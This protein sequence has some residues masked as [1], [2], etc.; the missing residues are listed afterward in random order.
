M[1]LDRIFD[2]FS[3]RKEKVDSTGKRLEDAFRNRVFMLCSDAFSNPDPGF[4]SADY[5]SEFWKQVHQKLTFL[6]GKPWLSNDSR[7][8]S[9]AEDSLIFLSQCED[10]HFLDFI[11]FVLKVDIYFRVRHDENQ[12]VEEI[13]TLFEVDD[14]PYALTPFV[15]EKQTGYLYGQE[16]E[17]SAIISY[18]KIISRD[19]E[20]TYSS[21]VQP[22]ISLLSDEGF[23]SANNEFIEALEDYRKGDYGDCL[24]KCG[25]SFES[26]MKIICSRKNWSYDENDS[27]AK[28]LKIIIDN[29]NLESF[30]EQPLIITATLR[31]RL[32][33]SHGSGV[34][35]RI[36]T[37]SKATFAINATASNIL[38]LVEY[39][40]EN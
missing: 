24:T 6:H 40:L 37:R 34:G 16:H 1:N 39:C 26:T 12:L 4:M 22:T 20:F 23:S 32:S 8:R 3:R 30:F 7:T 11:E 38:F 27:A 2:V 35:R 10:E 13:N 15:R 18:P 28:L 31:N 21:I 5:R 29:S 36:V 33:K 19:D 25:S 17:V 9:H 14:L